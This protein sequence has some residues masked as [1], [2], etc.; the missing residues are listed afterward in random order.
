MVQARAGLSVRSTPSFVFNLSRLCSFH[1]DFWDDL[2]PYGQPHKRFLIRPANFASL[3]Q[4]PPTLGERELLA[5]Y[6][7]FFVVLFFFDSASVFTFSVDCV[8]ASSKHEL[9]SEAEE[10][11]RWPTNT[12]LWAGASNLIC[13]DSAS[14]Y[15]SN[16]A[17]IFGQARQ[18]CP[19][20][21]D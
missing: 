20:R 16:S 21:E 12:C 6:L 5:V 11:G 19:W 13:G 7:G 18:R 3:L 2:L 15:G 4:Q 9:G 14:T 17:R 1:S 8:L 10:A